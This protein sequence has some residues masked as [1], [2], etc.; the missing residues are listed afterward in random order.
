MEK[1]GLLGRNGAGKT[2]IFKILS[3]IED[4]DS[5][6]VNVSCRVGILDQIPNI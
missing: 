1:V 4:Y 6:N 5:G 3:G 2:T